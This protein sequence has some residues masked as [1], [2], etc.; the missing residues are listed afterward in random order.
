MIYKY[1]QIEDNPT[2]AET[3]KILMGEFDDFQESIISCDLKEGIKAILT[4]KPDLVF[5]DVEL[6]GF[7]G[8]EFL[9]TLR[10]HLN[11]L[12]EII[13]TTAHE[14]YA[15]SAVNEEILYYLLKP[16]DP[17]E[18]FL[19]INKFRIKKAKAQKSITIKNQKGY[20]FLEFDDIFLIRSSSNYTYFYT[21]NFQSVL[22]SKTMK[23]FEP[24]L[25][26]SFIR[27]HK[28]FI[29]N[30]SFIRF[31]NTTKKVLQIAV[32]GLSDL[33]SDHEFILPLNDLLS[34]ER[35]LDIPIGEAFLDRVKNSVLY[36]KIG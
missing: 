24:Y 1:L 27:T 35:F 15:L 18:L 14:K 34:E 22:V 17:D 31:L 12:P 25:N 23:E 7:T 8:F 13:M 21:T 4:H 26:E 19:A 32:P 3:I 20:S 28:G 16:V 36:K 33:P 11:D 10:N 6:P 2:A 29:V 9:K 5:L 30:T